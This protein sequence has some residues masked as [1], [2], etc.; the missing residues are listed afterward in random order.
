MAP[1]FTWTKAMSFA[2]EAALRT[3]GLQRLAELRQEIGDAYVALD[4]CLIRPMCWECEGSLWGVEDDDP[5]R[6]LDRVPVLKTGSEPILCVYDRANQQVTLIF[7]DEQQPFELSCWRC[8][9]VL[10]IHDGETIPG[11]PESFA[12]YFKLPEGGPTDRPKSFKRT[13]KAIYGFKCVGCKE[14]FTEEDLTV[15]HVV[16]RAGGGDASPLNLQV[17]CQSCNA[18][19]ADRPVRSVELYLDILLRPQGE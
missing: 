17:L 14:E 12:E 16:A 6:P 2:F 4:I 8:G 13:L 3:E 10:E 5:L 18:K 15:D 7:H 1:E 19:K 11:Y 9:Q